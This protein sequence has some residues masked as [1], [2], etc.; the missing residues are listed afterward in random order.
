MPFFRPVPD[1]QTPVLHSSYPAASK[2]TL[3][4]VSLRPQDFLRM[5]P[6]FCD[7]SDK[8]GRG[9]EGESRKSQER[10]NKFIIYFKLAKDIRKEYNLTFKALNKSKR[11]MHKFFHLGRI[12]PQEFFHAGA[13]R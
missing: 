9:R 4:G 13:F 2:A 7:D 1:F 12:F 11:F 5:Q 8:I 3:K 6:D 10:M